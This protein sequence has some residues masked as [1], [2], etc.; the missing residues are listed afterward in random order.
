MATMTATMTPT[1]AVHMATDDSDASDAVH[2]E[3]YQGLID[4]IARLRTDIAQIL[5]RIEEIRQQ[6]IPQIKADYATTIGVWNTRL[7][8]MQLE[9]RRAKRRCALARMSVN[10]GATVDAEAITRQ[11]DEEFKQWRQQA[12]EERRRLRDLLRWRSSRSPMEPSKSK[13][14]NRLFRSLARRF[15]PDLFPGDDTRADYYAMACNALAN[16]DLALMQA[17]DA[18]T[19]DMTD[20]VDYSRLTTDEL[21]I[22]RELLEQ[23]LSACKASLDELTSTEPYTLRE[24]LADPDWVSSVVDGLRTRVEEF[25]KE[26]AHYDGLYE[27]MVKEAR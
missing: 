25:S 23:H 4:E 11:L 18:A 22:E 13:E 9:A 8:T 16:G 24:R 21:R 3:T 27:H 12:V 2:Q 15:H 26:K 1:M 20:H 17:L 19:A 5:A 7:I 14:L 6:E 10:H